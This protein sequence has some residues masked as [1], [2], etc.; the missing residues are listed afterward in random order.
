MFIDRFVGLLPKN[1]LKKALTY[2]NRGD[3]SKACK[4]FE[5][6][7]SR[8]GDARSGQD[9]EMVRMYMVEAY[10]GN[11]KHLEASNRYGEAAEQLEK[12]IAIEPGYADVHFNLAC[13]YENIGRFDASAE[14]LRRAISINPN[15]FKVRVMLAK[16]LHRGGHHAEAVEELSELLATAPTF[17]IEQVKELIRLIKADEHLEK[18]EA[19]FN[20]LLEERPSTAQVSK[21]VSLEAIQNGD[22]DFALN[23]LRKAIAM[24]PDYPDLHNLIGIAYANKGMTDD[25]VMEFETAL[26]IHPD[27]LKAH[28]NIALTLYEKG[29]HEEAMNH[30]ETVLRL[31]ADNELARN[32]LNELQPVTNKR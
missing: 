5:A 19:I 20:S 9:Q 17:F 16:N 10:I 6:Y 32:L 7:M 25:A 14:E 3:Y 24:N 31:D 30:L 28:L 23:E 26:K 2:F 1:T 13:L 4:E 29:V 15:F 27:Y 21:Q 8:H 12:A 18:R 11:A 22:Y